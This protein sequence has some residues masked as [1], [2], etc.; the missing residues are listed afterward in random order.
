MARSILHGR[1]KVTAGWAGLLL[2]A[3][4]PV[5]AS[6]Q[7]S[8]L[9]VAKPLAAVLTSSNAQ[10]DDTNALS[11]PKM[12]NFL[13]E[14]PS[15]D[16]RRVADWA[17]ASGDNAGL[18][19]VVIDKVSARVFVFDAQG[20]LRGESTALLGLAKGDSTAPG[21]GTAKLASIRPEQRT[22]PA[23]RFVAT[24]GHDFQ[25]D[26]LWVDYDAAISLHRVVAGNVGDHRLQRLAASSPAEK[27]ITYGC[28]NVPANFFDAVVLKAFAGTTGIVY[29]LPEVRKLEQVFPM[30]GPGSDRKR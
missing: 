29:I 21:I 14:R 13:N 22:T 10:P 2:L 3:S 20:Q 12:A 24:L 17:V 7:D 25:H 5:Q 8:D 1:A 27:R 19:Y 30:S 28:I 16:A 9:S 11:L 18:P 6:A 15:P 23:G 26:V 4:S